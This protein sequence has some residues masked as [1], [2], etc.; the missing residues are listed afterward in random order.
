VNRFQLW[1]LSWLAS[2]EEAPQYVSQDTL[3]YWLRRERQELL[4][5]KGKV[6]E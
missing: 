5:G 3:N 2:F 4:D 1:L 6:S